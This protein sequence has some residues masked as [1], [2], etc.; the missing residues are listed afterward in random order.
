MLRGEPPSKRPNPRYRVH[1]TSFWFHIRPRWFPKSATRFTYTFGLGW[2]SV[3]LLIIEGITGLI[4]MVPYTPSPDK[5]YFDILNIMGGVPFGSLMRDIHRLAAEAMV[6]SVVLHGIRVFIT[7]SYKRPRTFNWVV[8]VALGIITLVFSYSGYLL[9]WDQIAYWAIT[10]GSSMAETVPL[11]GKQFILLLRGAPDVGAAGLL[12]FYFWHVAL[13][14]I[15][16]VCM[17]GV[18]YYKVVRQGLSTPPGLE[19]KLEGKREERVP[20][21]PNI[22]VREALWVVIGLFILVV[23]AAFLYDAPLDDHANPYVTP[24]HATAPWYFLWVQGLI[25][26]PNVFGPVEGKLVWG[27]LVPALVFGF[28]FALPYIDRN[29]K[30]RWRDR[31]LLLG[32]GGIFAVAL[33]VLTYMGTPN[34]GLATPPAEDI[35]LEFAPGDGE[36]QIHEVPF[37]ALID[38]TY[39]TSTFT[40]ASLPSSLE[41][42]LSALKAQIESEEELPDGRAELTI[43]TWQRDLKRVDLTITWTEEGQAVTRTEKVYIHRQAH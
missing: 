25:K 36:G 32:L 42:F 12:R 33:V 35:L 24:L 20:F 26:L 43:Q 1:T 30:R 27:V 18:H 34:Y 28:L 15:A 10:I 5:A 19:E 13:V 4:L 3:F 7:A 40:A 17:L 2:I 37:E 38:G 41:K 14:P 16:M 8:G 23:A 29:P 11:I 31:K 21:L 39:D 22:L 9:T 6:V